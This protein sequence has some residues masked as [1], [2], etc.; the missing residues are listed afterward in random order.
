MNLKEAEFNVMEHIITTVKGLK[1]LNIRASIYKKKYF[2]TR[3]EFA[4]SPVE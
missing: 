2:T 4:D 3:A 1:N